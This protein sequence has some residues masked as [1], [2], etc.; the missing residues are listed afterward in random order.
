MVDLASHLHSLAE[1]GGSG[2]HDHELLEGQGVPGMHATVDDVEGRDRQDHLGVSG[3][4]RDVL[5]ERNSLLG[6][7]RAANGQRD[8][9]DGV[10]PHVGL[11]RGSV[12]IDHRLVDLLLLGRVHSLDLRSKMVVDVG[13]RLEDSLA[14]VVAASVTKLASLVDSGG[15]PGRHGGGE[16]SHGGNDVGLDGRVATGVEDLPGSDGNDARG[17]GLLQAVGHIAERIRRLPL[18][19]LVDGVLNMHLDIVGLEVL[20]VDLRGVRSAGSEIAVG[21][22]G[23]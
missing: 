5:V 4:L 23:A 20:L 7:S 13:D 16:R 18:D 14:H 1:G 11:V 2:R 17:G 21:I 3:K 8:G 15:S 6:G 9:Q 10:R 12:Q 22:S 19:D